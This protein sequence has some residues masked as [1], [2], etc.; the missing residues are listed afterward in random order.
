MT[1]EQLIL[2]NRHDVPIGVEEKMAVHQKGLLHRAF[3]VFL[4][5]ERDELLLQRRAEQKYHSGGLWSN[6]C[7]GHPR[8]G[9]DIVNSA[10]RRLGEELGISCDLTPIG[11]FAYRVAFRNGLIENE[12]DHVI[13]GRYR[14]AVRPNPNEVS[15]WR[16]EAPLTLAGWL[17]A[18]PTLFTHWFALAFERFRLARPG[19]LLASVIPHGGGAEE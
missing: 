12:I 9:E 10:R 19:R 15:D 7:C 6:T 3:S 14:G 4:F 17:V 13:V 5:N 2:V 16:W 11:R 1:K 18:E 8:P